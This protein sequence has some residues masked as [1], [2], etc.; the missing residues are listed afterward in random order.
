MKDSQT[1]R[2]IDKEITRSLIDFPSLIIS[3]EKAYVAQVNGDASPPQ[4]I[5]MSV[6]DNFVHYKAGYLKGSQ[7][8][9][10]KYSGGF[11]ENGVTDDYG[12]VIVHSAQTGLPKIMFLDNGTITDYRTASAG[13]VASK[14]CSREDST[15]VGMIGAG[16]QARLQIEALLYVRPR[17]S[18]VQVWSRN[19]TSVTS[20]LKVMQEKFPHIT[21]IAKNTPEEAISGVDIVITV[22]PSREPIVKPEWIMH[23]MHITAVGACAPYMQEHDPKVIAKSSRI[24]ADSIEKCL[25]DGELHHAINTKYIT[26]DQITGEIGS[27]ISGKL[28][29]RLTDNDITFVDLVGLGIQDATAAETLLKK[30]EK[31]DNS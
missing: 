1:I 30:L 26:K 11:W 25:T 15:V 7:Y 4:Y 10:V 17:I 8:F 16:T 18:K 28:K 5:N 13:A 9:T 19:E 27:V 3:A 29:G 23:G 14:Y 12:Y 31:K 22:T 24:F 2:I 21:F 6:G 20:Y